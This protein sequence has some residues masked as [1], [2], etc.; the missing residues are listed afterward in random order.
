MN[1]GRSLDD[2]TVARRVSQKKDEKSTSQT[3]PHQK[4]KDN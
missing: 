4:E 2:P 3:D 1:I